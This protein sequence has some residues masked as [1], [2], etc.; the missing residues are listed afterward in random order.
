LKASSWPEVEAAAPAA[1]REAGLLSTIERRLIPPP[2]QGAFLSIAEKP[3]S[4]PEE[5]AAAA[6]T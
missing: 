2:F 6:A 3:A 1:E 4:E 5:E